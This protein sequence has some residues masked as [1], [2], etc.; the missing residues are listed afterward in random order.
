MSVGKI[1]PAVPKAYITLMNTYK[2][3]IIKGKLHV[4]AKL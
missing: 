2:A 3:N 1:N 4:P